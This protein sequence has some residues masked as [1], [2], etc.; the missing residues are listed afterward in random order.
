MIDGSTKRYIET[1][2]PFWDFGDTLNDA[3]YADCGLRATFGSPT[4]TVYGLSHL[5]GEAVVGLADGI[6]F[7]ID[8]VI[9]VIDGSVTLDRT[10]TNV[11]VGKN[12]ES[13]AETLNLEAGA[14]DGTAQGKVGR[15]H[16][17]SVAVWDSLM[18][19]I[20]VNN[21]DTLND[22]F[23]P[24][25][26][27]EQYREDELGVPQLFTGIIG[28]LLPESN[29]GKRKSIIFRQNRPYPHNVVAIMPQLDTQDR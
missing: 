11:V 23:T 19:E 29:Y 17:V 27:Q 9:T 3:F 2:E 22:E 16:N 15:I 25:M 13:L 12:F 10:F 14:A 20:G 18:G 4:D 8:E 21:E 26:T 6:M 28:P 1:L 7:G 5:E 24:A